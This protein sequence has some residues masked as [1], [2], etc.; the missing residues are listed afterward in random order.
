MVK[1]ICPYCGSIYG[2]DDSCMNQL[3]WTIQSANAYGI[4]YRCPICYGDSNDK[5]IR[6]VNCS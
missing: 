5:D 1:G 4:V 2:F 6:R 3:S